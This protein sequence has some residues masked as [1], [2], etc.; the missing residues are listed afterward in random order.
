MLI[1]N[2][3]FD[4]PYLRLSSQSHKVP[5][6]MVTVITLIA[7]VPLNVLVETA[8]LFQCFDCPCSTLL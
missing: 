8:T 2:G 6:Q 1:D 3:N 4:E 7:Q 5:K